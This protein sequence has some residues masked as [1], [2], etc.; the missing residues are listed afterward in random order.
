LLSPPVLADGN[1]FLL[2][3]LSEVL[4]VERSSLLG[5]HTNSRTNILIPEVGN[6]HVLI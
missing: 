1:G 2:S 3:S 5:H 4:Q 6:N